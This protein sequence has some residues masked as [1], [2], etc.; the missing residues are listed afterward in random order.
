[1]LRVSCL[2]ATDRRE[3]DYI[4]GTQKRDRVLEGYCLELGL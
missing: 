2:P 1:M 4:Q 3:T